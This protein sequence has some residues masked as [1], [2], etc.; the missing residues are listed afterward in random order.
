MTR[1]L[2]KSNKYAIALIITLLIVL[3]IGKVPQRIYD[4]AQLDNY[5]QK[6]KRYVSACSQE[7][8]VPEQ[9][10]YA[11]IKTESNFRP[12]VRSS[13]GAVGLMQLMP[14]TFEWLTEQMLRENLPLYRRTDPYTNI[15][16]GTYMLS[17]LYDYYGD[18]ETVFAAY[19]AGP[20]RVNSWLEDSRYSSNGKLTY[21]PNSE[22]RAYVQRQLSNIEKYENLYYTGE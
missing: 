19:N 15:R 18:W 9:I 6:Y 4:A 22:T 13:A 8:G 1:N 11:T 16:Y 3:V 7:F 2:Y 17:W 12:R 10:I 20:G 21:I 5:P 14:D